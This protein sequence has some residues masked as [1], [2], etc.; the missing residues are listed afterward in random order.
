MLFGVSEDPFDTRST[1]VEFA[2]LPATPIPVLA[3][4]KDTFLLFGPHNSKIAM[5]WEVIGLWCTST[6]TPQFK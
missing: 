1:S 4:P 5:T 2:P 6:D 3:V